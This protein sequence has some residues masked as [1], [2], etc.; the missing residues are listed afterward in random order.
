VARAVAVV[1]DFNVLVL[2]AVVEVVAVMGLDL[3]EL[4]AQRVV[5]LLMVNQ[6]KRGEH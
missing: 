1:A 5:L 6:V 3:V 2:A 4:A